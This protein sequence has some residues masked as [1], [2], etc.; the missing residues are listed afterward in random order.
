M[1]ETLSSQCL[2]ATDLQLKG[3]SS[4]TC[5]F[6]SEFMFVLKAISP[7]SSPKVANL[8][9]WKNINN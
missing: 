3:L 2:L 6:S 1:V 5:Q 4:Y 9:L 8:I 7:H